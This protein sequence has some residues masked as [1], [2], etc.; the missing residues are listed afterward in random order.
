MDLTI[1]CWELAD[2]DDYCKDDFMGRYCLSRQ[3]K[4]QIIVNHIEISSNMLLVLE[5]V[6]PY[7]QI[8]KFRNLFRTEHFFHEISWRYTLFLTW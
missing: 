7:R 1:P 3:K 2:D 6:N 5:T 4:L 8:G